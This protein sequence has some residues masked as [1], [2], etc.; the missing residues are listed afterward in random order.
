[1]RPRSPEDLFASVR[2]HDDEGLIE[3]AD[4]AYEAMAAATVAP[5][6]EE[7]VFESR[8]L[9]SRRKERKRLGKPDDQDDC[10]FCSHVGERGAAPIPVQEVEELVDYLRANFGVIKT[11]TLALQLEEQ[12]ERIRE[13]V[14]ARCL[15]GE[16]PLRPM[17]AA[18]ILEHIRTHVNDPQWK[19]ILRLE[20][21]SELIET[22]AGNYLFQKSAKTKRVR[23]DP[24]GFRVLDAL[25]KWEAQL[26]GK[27]PSEM[28]QYASNAR[29][30]PEAQNVGPINFSNKNITDFFRPKR[31]KT[32]A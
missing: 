2:G 23:I 11:M 27:K 29:I 1:M 10:F 14:N 20:M 15:P 9:K 12:F 3:A 6:E 25:G 16:A 26:Q 21:A 32:R 5:E 8:G 17:S 18:T 24:V 4:L 30:A 22:V 13:S 28:A 19:L 31:R 7:E